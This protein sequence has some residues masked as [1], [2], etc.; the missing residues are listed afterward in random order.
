MALQRHLF[1]APSGRPAN[2]RGS[3]LAENLAPEMA[4]KAVTLR[5]A[6]SHHRHTGEIGM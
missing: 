5:H 2:L 3:F 1:T 6:E 4:R